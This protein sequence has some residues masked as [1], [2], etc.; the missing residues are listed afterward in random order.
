MI[1][2]KR[3]ND[4]SPLFSPPFQVFYAADE[5]TYRPICCYYMAAEFIHT[6]TIPESYL[7]ESGLVSFLASP[8]VKGVGK[9]YARKIADSAG[10]SVLN[11]EFSFSSL[12]N[13]IPGLSANKIEDLKK[14]LSNLKVNPYAGVLLYSAGMADIEVEK[15]LGHYGKKAEKVLLEDPYDMVE[16]AWKVSFFTADKLG[17]LLGVEASDPRR[18]RGAL[19]TAV[20]FYAEKGNLFATESQA[21]STA[22]KL[23]GVDEEAVKNELESLIKDE[24]LIRSHDGIYLPVYYH[25]EK[26]A[27]KKIAAMVRKAPIIPEDY[28]I[29]SA[30]IYGNPLNAKQILALKTVMTHPVTVISGGPGTGKTTAVRG[31]IELFEGMDRKVVLAAPTGRAAKRMAELAGA[32]AKTIHRLLGY[33]YGKGY[34]NKRFKAD[35]LVID[36]ASMLE[37]VLFN[38]LLDAIEEGT[39]VVLVGDTNQLPPIGAGDVLNELIKS[40]TVPIVTLLENYRQKAGSTI[41]GTAETIKAGGIPPLEEA[42]DFVMQTAEGTDEIRH[43]VLS[44]VGKE[45]PEKYGIDP[46]DIQVVTPQNDGPLGARELNEELQRHVNPDGPELSRGLKRFRLGDRVMQVSN[47]SEQNVYNGETG[48]ISDIDIENQCLEVTFHDGKKRL[49]P[50]NRL[51]EL[52]L[53]YA[54]TVHKLQGSETDYMVMLLTSA[55]RQ[56]LY[57]NLLY[58]GISRARKLCVLVCEKRAIGTALDNTSPSQ[59]NSNF[60]L[61][62]QKRLP[63]FPQAH[64]P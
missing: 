5:P 35:I 28:E 16:N 44:L 61:R 12:E 19:L 40:G 53:A 54:M 52:N 63:F 30:D 48:W 29:P 6:S 13:K 1:D 38:H 3:E 23:A 56:M 27:A 4:G 18:I 51:S 62:L 22:A 31:I 36:E 64:K 49:Y 41:A 37:Q 60:S 8:Y 7:T 20:K 55:H 45:I 15:I 50:K 24:R 9:V 46:R 2:G 34:R 14:S 43:T 26:E 21:V 47:S 25:A 39:K 33:N 17:R 42:N 10:F 59:R 32:E 58:T 57:R 11:P